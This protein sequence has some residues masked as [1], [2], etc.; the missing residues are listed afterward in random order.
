MAQVLKIRAAMGPEMSAVADTLRDTFG[1][2]L[3][4]LETPSLTMGTKPEEGIPTQLP[5]ERKR[6]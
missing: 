3:T 5:V 6:A 4:W 2:K 1:A